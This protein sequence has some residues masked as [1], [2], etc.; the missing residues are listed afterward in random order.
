[1]DTLSGIGVLDKV[2]AV[3]GAVAEAP[4]TLA[5]LQ[6]ATALPRATAHR[7]AAALEV[8]GWLRRDDEG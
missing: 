8:H 2:V 5:D 1:M 6:A 3:L 7:L 4:R